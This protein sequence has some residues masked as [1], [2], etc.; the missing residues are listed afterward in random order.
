MSPRLRP[1]VVRAPRH[2]IRWA[3]ELLWALSAHRINLRYRETVLGM[4]WILFQPV[5]LTVI[6]TYIFKRFAQVSSGSVPYP[7][8]TA[9]GLVAWSITALVV[10]AS[11]NV[12]V[13]NY[14]LL[15]RIA[16]P[17]ILFPISTVVATL[18]DLGILLLLLLLIGWHYHAVLPATAPWALL[19]LVVHVAFL[20]GVACL[21]SL[22]NVFLK[23]VGHA[24]PSL[25][26]LWFF[27]SPVFY[28]A[29]MVPREFSA[30]AQWNPMT[31]LIEGYRAVL[32]AGQPLPWSLVG[33]TI[34]TTAVMLALALAAFKRLDG[35]M[36]DLL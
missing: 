19:L 34:V 13:G 36:A 29:S 11:A 30:L 17:R 9:T 23:D 4:G 5:A 10:G 26:Q 24:I 22:A 15:K 25:L 7:L 21:A 32:L 16:L 33:P 1:T 14:A 27:A 28:P 8:F 35:T 31:G 6:L 2:S 20:V 18:A 3:L 12:L